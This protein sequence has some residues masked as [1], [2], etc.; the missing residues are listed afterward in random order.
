M[1]DKS[2]INQGHLPT[3]VTPDIDFTDEPVS[4]YD[5]PCVENTFIGDCKWMIKMI[6]NWYK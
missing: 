3:K 6:N 5:F 1:S 4:Q 2:N